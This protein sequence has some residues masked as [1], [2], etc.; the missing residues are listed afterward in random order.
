VAQNILALSWVQLATYVVP[1]LTLPY[2]ARQ[3]G[4]SALGLVVFAQSLSLTLYLLLEYGFNL[5]STRDVARRRERPGEIEAIVAGVTGAKLVLVALGTLVALACMLAVPEFRASPEYLW[6]AWLDALALGLMPTWYFQGIER[7]RLFAAGQFAARALAAVGIF[8]LVHDPDDGW[9]VLALQ[10]AFDGLVTI[11]LL[12]VMARTVRFRRPTLRGAT[13][14]LRDGR[15]MFAFNAAVSLYTAV[16]SFALGLVAPQSQVGYFG[17]AEKIARAGTRLMVPISM[18]LFPRVSSMI[19][20]GAHDAA[21][22]VARRALLVQTA[23]GTAA[24][25][26]LAAS[27]PWVVDVLFGPRFT[28][29]EPA[30]RILALMLP[31]VAVSN[32]LGIQWMLPLGLDRSF[33]SV[34]VGAAGLNVALL[35]TLGSAFGATGAAWAVVAAE[36]TV[37]VGLVAVLWRRRMLPLARR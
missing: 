21:R 16:N 35:L 30:L 36:T 31:L 9:I 20:R 22:R 28:E 26:A 24:A 14:T 4:P 23:L 34:C 27:A 17:S 5:S 29:A 7:M 13:R 37:A 10:A 18:S 32:V 19:E 8:A 6:L 15:S 12:A 11:A 2:L 1:L 25:A 3:L 33:V